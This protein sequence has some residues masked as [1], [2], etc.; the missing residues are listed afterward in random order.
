M[1]TTSNRPAQHTASEK[2][3]GTETP[4]AR[5]PL[6]VLAIAFALCFAFLVWMAAA[7]PAR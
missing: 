1:S 4:R 6:V 3:L 2:P 7:Y 5:W